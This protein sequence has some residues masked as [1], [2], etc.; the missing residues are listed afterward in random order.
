MKPFAIGLILLLNFSLAAQSKKE[1]LTEVDHLK[2]EIEQLKKPKTID[3]NNKHIQASYAL[4]ILIGENLHTQGGDSLD[5]EAIAAGIRDLFLGNTLKLA[6]EECIAVV[7][8]YMQ[9]AMDN[10]NKKLKEENFTFLESNKMNDGVTVTP[11]GLQYKVLQAG[12]GNSPGL[13]D[14]VTV[15]YVG[16][17]IDGT[18]FDQSEKDSP[19]T[20]VVG[21]VIP[22][23][24]E[25]LLL[26]HEGD[27]W[28]LYLPYPLGYGERGAMPD[29]P[30][31]ATLIFE[32]E[33]LK[34]N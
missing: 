29:I 28:E 6:K 18:V 19:I 30:P 23:W 14:S 32:I 10:R 12:N 16:K 31:Y 33:L 17:L 22:G 26:M 24:S 9:A 7:Q 8:P 5:A 11:T 2:T 13:E 25:A 4:G 34:V 1:L 3:L 20:F 27:R 21:E 15:H